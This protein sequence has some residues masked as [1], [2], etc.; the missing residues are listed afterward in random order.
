[1][2]YYHMKNKDAQ[3]LLA[4]LNLSKMTTETTRRAIVA[5]LVPI[6]DEE[7]RRFKNWM[8][9]NRHLLTITRQKSVERRYI[10]R[11]QAM[12]IVIHMLDRERTWS[13][14]EPSFI[15]QRGKLEKD[16]WK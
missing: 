8:E 3:K 14:D 11:I 15:V 16:R 1:M 5:R 6:L 13:D 4:N 7:Q 9:A 10:K 2:I 12:K